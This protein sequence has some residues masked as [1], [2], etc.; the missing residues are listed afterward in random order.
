MEQKAFFFD[1]DGIVNRRVVGG[2]VRNIGELHILPYFIELFR[3]VK[4]SG[5]LAILVTNQQ[6]VG[7][8][9]ISVETLEEIHNYMQKQ[10]L[11]A[12]GYNFDA[13]YYCPDLADSGSSYRKPAT[14]MF[15]DAIKKYGVNPISSY[16]VGD[17]VS[18]VEAGK[19]VGSTTILV[20]DYADVLSADYIF[21]DLSSVYDFFRIKFNV[22]E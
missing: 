19:Q 8:G 1:R 7:K 12:S 15:I 16:T 4:E 9:I 5:F 6:C 11:I 22:K 13:I 14:G 21:H 2:Y 18:D 3:L 17:S 20:G 10:L